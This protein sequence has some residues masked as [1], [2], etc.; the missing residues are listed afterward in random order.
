MAKTKNYKNV[1]D[2]SKDILGLDDYDSWLIS[3]KNKIIAKIV[4][5]RKKQGLSQGELA[6]MLGTT[7]SVISRI[8]N[9]TTRHITIDYLMKIVTVLGVS[10]KIT[11]KDAA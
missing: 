9:G 5:S 1:G 3:V 2:F 4:K 11:F 8:E 6:E 10:P 7:Q